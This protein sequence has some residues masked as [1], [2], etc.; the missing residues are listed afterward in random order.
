MHAGAP[1][2]ARSKE[3]SSGLSSSQPA[4]RRGREVRCGT[5]ERS[6]ARKG[7]ASCREITDCGTTCRSGATEAVAVSTGAISSDAGSMP[8]S[9]I[10][11]SLSDRA[12]SETPE[13][14]ASS[15]SSPASLT[16]VVAR[17]VAMPSRRLSCSARCLSV[18]TAAWTRARSSRN[19]RATAWNFVRTTGVT[20]P[21]RVASSTSRAIRANVEMASLR[22]RTRCCFRGA[23]RRAP[24]WRWPGRATDSSS[25]AEARWPRQ[26]AAR[27]RGR[28]GTSPSRGLMLRTPSRRAD[29]R[30]STHRTSVGLTRTRS[31]RRVD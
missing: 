20:R 29:L 9:R 21:R 26:H 19:S 17:M 15:A 30:G 24:V 12:E 13:S 4:R 7:F 3:L 2:P 25:N 5:A 22:W 31:R 6:E 1:P 28:G 10:I 11:S 27:S 16:A 23:V 14:S 18:A 8:R